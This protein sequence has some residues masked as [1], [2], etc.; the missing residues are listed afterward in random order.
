MKSAS[1]GRRS[2]GSWSVIVPSNRPDRLAEFL[3]AW[4]PLFDQYDVALHLVIDSADGVSA[5]PG[6]KG[7]IDSWTS[8]PDWVPRRTDMIRS[9]GIY[10]AWIQGSDYVL[11]LDDDVRPLG[12]LFAA[13]EKVF[14]SGAPVSPFLDVGALTS[15]GLQMRG[16]PYKDRVKQPV[17]VQYGGW[18][19]VL[20]YDAQT[21][22]TDPRGFEEFAPLDVPV[23]RGAGVTGCAMNMA[24]QHD[25]S[26]AMWQLPM[27]DG[28]YNRFG[29]IWSGLFAKKTLDWMNQGCVVNG[30]AQVLHER[31]SD[32]NVNLQ[33]ELP[34]IPVNETLWDMLKVDE[35]TV[36]ENLVSV[37]RSVTD[38]AIRQFATFDAGYANWFT[39]CRDQWLNLY[40]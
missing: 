14:V 12:D 39:Q 35:N 26:P 24:W 37:Y 31:A 22:L 8:I 23:P 36:G 21:Q 25:F 17:Q 18:S 16:F 38:S 27:L 2:M 32:P 10:R 6:A 1:G 29:D 15:S 11:S 7:T 40:Q 34:G 20:D 13:Y 33:R 9:W 4:K 28:R 5:A 30:H 19:G 3:A